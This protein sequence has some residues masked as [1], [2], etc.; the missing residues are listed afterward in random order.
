MYSSEYTFLYPLYAKAPLI[1]KTTNTNATGWYPILQG[2]D[3]MF[4]PTFAD[5]RPLMLPRLRGIDRV[6]LLTSS[7][8]GNLVRIH[9]VLADQGFTRAEQHG[10][11]GTQ[12]ELWERQPG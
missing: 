4:A 1:T 2:V 6:W 8:L 3:T 5:P 7:R 11:P 9:R 10:T 12:L